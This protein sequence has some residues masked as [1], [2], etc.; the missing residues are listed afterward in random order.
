MPTITNQVHLLIISSLWNIQRIESFQ[1]KG[2]GH[3]SI[4]Y[5]VDDENAEKFDISAGKWSYWP[6]PTVKTGFDPCM[7]E[8]NNKLYLIGGELYETGIQVPFKK[9]VRK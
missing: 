2:V 3:K 1:T 5:I 4:L 7:V 6:S 9:I 8:L